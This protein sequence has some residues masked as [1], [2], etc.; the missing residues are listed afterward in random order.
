MG[1]IQYTTSTTGTKT[2]LYFNKEICMTVDAHSTSP[3]KMLA[4][5]P[6]SYVSKE[7]SL[8]QAK[9]F[10]EAL[11]ND[12][13]NATRFYKYIGDNIY[14]LLQDVNGRKYC[15]NDT[16]TTPIPWELTDDTC[17]ILGLH[18]NKAIWKK[19]SGDIAIY[20]YT[21]EI[22]LP[23]GPEKR[24]GLP[25]MIMKTESPITHISLTATSIEIPYKGTVQ[26]I[27]PGKD[28]PVISSKEFKKV[29]D[30]NNT[31]VMEM[32]KMYNSKKN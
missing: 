30:K 16:I 31:D 4:A 27:P 14:R 18:C 7:D 11:V 21:P 8:K 9:A 32:I 19:E 17:T 13:I 2:N 3:E 24:G 26:I 10:H 6:Q 23:F 29:L 22:P 28:I 1:F 12:S 25:G 15:V 20:W 5:N